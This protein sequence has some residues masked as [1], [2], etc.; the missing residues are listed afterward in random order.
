MQNPFPFIVLRRHKMEQCCEKEM[1]ALDST[2]RSCKILQDG[3]SS[4]ADSVKN[5]STVPPTS[6]STVNA[7]SLSN[8]KCGTAPKQLAS[9]TSTKSRNWTDRHPASGVRSRTFGHDSKMTVCTPSNPPSDWTAGP[10]V[11]GPNLKCCPVRGV[12]IREE[13][14]WSHAW[15]RFKRSNG[16][17]LNG[18]NEWKFCSKP[19]TAHFRKSNVCTFSVST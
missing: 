5:P 17:K 14:H 3:V 19:S 7:G 10:S 9:V 11:F 12:A 4:S 16:V 8:T 15:Q 6:G 18:I 2:Q 1:C 13:C